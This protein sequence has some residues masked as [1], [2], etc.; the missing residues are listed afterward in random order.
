MARGALPHAPIQ[1]TAVFKSKRRPIAIPQSE[2]LKLVGALA[3]LWGNAEFDFPQIKR[4]SLVAGVGLHDRGYGFLDKAAVLEMPEAQWLEITRCG[5]DMTSSDPAADLIT[6]YHLARLTRG[7]PSAAAQELR[8]V[9]ER[10]IEQQLHEQ[11]FAAALFERI[12]RI[13]DLCD[14][15]SFSFCLEESAQ[16]QV[17]I[18]ARNTDESQI[19]VRYSFDQTG[20]SVDPWPFS[21][22]SITGYI[23]GYRLPEYPTRLDPVI[24]PYSLSRKK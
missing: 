3:F 10:K 8:Q 12:D 18:F 6:R 7:N 15:I 20:I 5:F 9:F 14:K 1:E 24:L 21:V 23:V 11:G 13:T 19:P 2:H 17:S 4:L 22:E 16:G